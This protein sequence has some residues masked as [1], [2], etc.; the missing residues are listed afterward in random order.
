LA[1]A[2]HNSS[3]TSTPAAESFEADIVRRVELTGSKLLPGRS[4]RGATYAFNLGPLSIASVS[5][6]SPP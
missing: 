6:V 2:T 1:V 3:I 5:F 4:G